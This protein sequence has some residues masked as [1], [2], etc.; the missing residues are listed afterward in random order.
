MPSLND[1]A[2]NSC[3][4]G[5]TLL[6][7]LKCSSPQNSSDEFHTWFLQQLCSTCN[8]FRA[9][10]IELITDWWLIN[11]EILRQHLHDAVDEDSRKNQNLA[12]VSLSNCRLENWKS[13]NRWSRVIWTDWC[14]TQAITDA[15]V[16]WNVWRNGMWNWLTTLAE[17]TN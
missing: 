6:D 3:E 8:G 11:P 17:K 14:F 15:E 4:I 12:R 7:Q 2:F 13:R 9:L 10:H 16:I 1:N 5:K